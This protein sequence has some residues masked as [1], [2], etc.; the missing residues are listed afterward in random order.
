MVNDV[1]RFV[2]VGL[3]AGA[4]T[5]SVSAATTEQTVTPIEPLV[6]QRVEGVGGP[7][8]QR[9]EEL[10]AEQAEQA[11]NGTDPESETQRAAST[12]GKVVLV[13][14][15]TAVSVA[16]MVASLLFF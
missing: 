7:T 14:L 16:T 11:V 5:G 1:R 3:L 15:T 9:V 13:V 8:E 6:E 10:S 4:L 12:A 2:A